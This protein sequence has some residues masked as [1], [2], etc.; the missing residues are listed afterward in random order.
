MTWFVGY[1]EVDLPQPE[2]SDCGAFPAERANATFHG[3]ERVHTP[4][5]TALIRT[6]SPFSDAFTVTQR[7]T[8]VYG[9][10]AQTP[11]VSHVLCKYCS[12][13]GPDGVRCSYCGANDRWRKA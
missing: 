9:P 11:P 10:A 3:R 2:L 7:V 1:E 8:S 4:F 6:H 13:V 12:T 5:Y